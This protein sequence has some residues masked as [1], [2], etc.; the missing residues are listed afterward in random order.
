MDVEDDE[1]EESDEE[2]V[3]TM[4]RYTNEGKHLKPLTTNLLF[5]FYLS[6]FMNLDGVE[7]DI[8]YFYIRSMVDLAKWGFCD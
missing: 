4:E 8:A 6:L 1:S 7:G 5:Q 3:E 2:E